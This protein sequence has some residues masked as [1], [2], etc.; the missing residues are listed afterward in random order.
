MTVGKEQK[1]P[2]F[3]RLR[4][5][6][7]T[8]DLNGQRFGRLVITGYAGGDGKK[9]W[10]Q[11][12]CDCGT[13]KLFVGAELRKGHTNSCGCLALESIKTRSV[14]HG[15]SYHAAYGVW[16]SMLDRCELPSHKAF[17]RYGGR[18]ITVCERWHKFADFWAD[19]GPTWQRG[20]TI[21]RLNNEA[22]YSPRNCAWRDRKAQARNSRGNVIVDTPKGPML[23]CEASDISGINV[24]TLCYR[25][26]A[27]WPA[28]RM[29]DPPDFG[30]RWR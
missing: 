24:T 23:I 15:M 26:G 18:G 30:N 4:P 22:G 10:W 2:T 14:T 21:E 7:R 17:K 29:F 16:N 3:T 25:I 27:G 19:M 11:A 20:L 13:E 5:H 12:R 8:P 6:H 28:S 9:S 1:M